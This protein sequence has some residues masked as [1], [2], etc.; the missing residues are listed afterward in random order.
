MWQAR[1]EVKV[2]SV[3]TRSDNRDI[4]ILTANRQQS[5]SP[6]IPV[7]KYFKYFILTV[8]LF[9]IYSHVNTTRWLLLS[10]FAGDENKACKH[11]QGETTGEQ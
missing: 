2:K 9:I 5:R 3:D 6:G 1:A 7:A 8:I 4:R 10:H 11:I